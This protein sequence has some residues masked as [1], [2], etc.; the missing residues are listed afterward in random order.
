MNERGQ[1]F[2]LEAFVAA[3]L[4]LAT[5][6][7]TLQITGV[8]ANTPSTADEHLESQHRGMAEGVLDSAAE[9]ESL[10]PTLLYWN[11]T[12]GAF[13][14]ATEEHYVAR[15]PPTAFGATLDRSFD[16]RD[17]RYNVD[18]HYISADGDV[19]RRELVRHGTPS[20]DA[21]R[22][23]KTVTLYDDDR[24]YDANRTPTNVTLDETSGFYAPDASPDSPV[25][26]VVRVEVV[27]W[28]T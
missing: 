5:V 26:N 3:V 18:I 7:F 4:L 13:H 2:T 22:A 14:N 17:I 21:T 23:V 12:V 10:G 16:G 27:V 15:S 11:D 1:A 24:L 19:Q 9:N 25:Y 20:D 28:R 6:G 8:T